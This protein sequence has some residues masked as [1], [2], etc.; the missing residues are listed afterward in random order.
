MNVTVTYLSCALHHTV[1]ELQQL[2]PDGV[3]STCTDDYC[4]NGGT[5][6]VPGVCICPEPWGGIR[7]EDGKFLP[8]T[9]PLQPSL[10]S[11]WVSVPLVR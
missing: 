11:N 7:C 6:A 8:Q 10:L 1:E 2:T 4:L 5:C 9:I 3:Y